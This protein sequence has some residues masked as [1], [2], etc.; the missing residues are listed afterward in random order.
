MKRNK[1]IVLILAL[2][3]MICCLFAACTEN[4]K[5]D[6]VNTDTTYTA[7]SSNGGVAVQYGNYLYFINGYVGAS[8][9]NTFGSV[10]TGAVCRVE[11][12][13]DNDGK[14]SLDYDTFQVVV[15]KNVYG[16]D[17][18]NGGI[19]IADGY[20]YYHTTSVDKNSK[21]EYKTDEGVLMRTKVDGTG[22]ETLKSFSDNSTV[23]R[24]VGNYLIYTDKDEDSNNLLKAIKLSDLSDITVES[25]NVIAYN[26]SENYLVY[27]TYNTER[28]TNSSSD[29]LVKLFDGK[30]GEKK[31]LLSSDIYNAGTDVKY[32][33]TTT[34]KSVQETASSIYLFYTK[35]DN[36]TNDIYNGY[37]FCTFPKADPTYN[38]NTE[39]RMTSQTDT[40]KYERFF[41]L[42][43]KGWIL[44]Y[45]DKKFDVYDTFVAGTAKR[46]ET[47]DAK[48]GAYLSYDITGATD[49]VNVFETEN[50]EVY[51]YYT[52]SATIDNTSYTALNYIKMFSFDTAANTYKTV[53]ENVAVFFYFNYNS[54]YTTYE[55]SD[56]NYYDANGVTK[57][58]AIVYL[59][60][61]LG[62]DAFACYHIIQDGND[63]VNADK[64]PSGKL[65]GK[66]EPEKFVDVISS[67]AVEEK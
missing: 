48:N 36:S 32:L 11:I 44:A 64:K 5:W 24:I 8:A 63:Q 6:T 30:T 15:P 3:L 16:S 53:E 26:F 23:F 55:V 33:Y 61:D 52:T 17:T 67:G 43:K 40:T 60:S 49:L 27:T 59:N 19:Y 58:K 13:K 47:G 50:N 21:R 51:A 9:L 29:Y 20:I 4:T 56:L 22:T 14:L 28:K 38:R 65:L 62:D 2:V 39:Y 31:V 1:N 12:K 42:E 25:N 34:I 54:T 18:T 35:D 7:V 45:A 41:C 46:A 57:A 66:I 10:K 37:Y